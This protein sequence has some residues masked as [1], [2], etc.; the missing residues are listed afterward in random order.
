[1]FICLPENVV[2]QDTF[3]LGSWDQWKSP[4]SIKNYNF[5]ISNYLF[6]DVGDFEEVEYKLKKAEA[7]FLVN[8]DMYH[9][10][11]QGGITN[12][13]SMSKEKNVFW[14]GKIE[15]RVMKDKIEVYLIDKIIFQGDFK[16]GKVKGKGIYF[17]KNGI[18]QYEGEILNGIIQG[19]GTSFFENGNKWYEGNFNQNHLNGKG[20]VYFENGNKSYEG[21]FLNGLRNGNGILYYENGE[22]MFSGEFLNN[23]KYGEGILYSID[24]K[25]VYHGFFANDVYHGTGILY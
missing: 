24:G 18:K 16:N 1:M 7:Y 15:I 14:N 4:I 5:K 6:Y 11:L 13:L 12:N 2:D 21:N 20:I 10:R 23:L 17:A 22:E 3:V 19:Q 8:D 25:I 9:T